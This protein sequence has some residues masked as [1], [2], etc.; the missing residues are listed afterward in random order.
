M[1]MWIINEKEIWVKNCF[2]L[3]VKYNFKEHLL[4]RLI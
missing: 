3:E 4:G 1:V 2:G